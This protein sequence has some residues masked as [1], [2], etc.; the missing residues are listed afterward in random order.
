MCHVPCDSCDICDM[1]D[2]PLMSQISHESR[3]TWLMIDMPHPHAE[4]YK[5]DD[6]LQKRPIIFKSL[7]TVATLYVK[8]ESWYCLE[9]WQSHVWHDPHVDVSCQTWAMSNVSHVKCDVILSCVMAITRVTRPSCRCVM[10]NVSHVKREPCQMWVI[11]YVWH[12]SHVTPVTATHGNTGW[13]RPM[14]CLILIGHFPQKSPIM[15]GSFAKN[16]LQLNASYVSSPPCI[17]M[18]GSHTCDRT[19]MSQISHHPRRLVDSG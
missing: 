19:L 1:C 4:P 3:G 8:R 10:S 18:C 14:G 5:R 6:I 12:E 15:S 16:N 2:M 9:S 13:R 17:A 11:W 7:L